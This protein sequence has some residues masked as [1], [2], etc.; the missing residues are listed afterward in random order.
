MDYLKL[1]QTHEE[2]EAFVS[3][4]TMVKPNVS[5]CV[6]EN[7][8]HYN[9]IEEKLI[10]SYF[11]YGG[12]YHNQIYCYINEGGLEAEIRAVDVFDKVEIDGVEVSTSYLDSIEAKYPF[13]E[14]THTVAYTLKDPTKIDDGMFSWCDGLTSVVFP[15]TIR[16]IGRESFSTCRDLNSITFRNG[17]ISIGTLAFFDCFSLTSITFPESITNIGEGCFETCE[18]IESVTVK[19]SVPPTLGA[20]VFEYS[21]SIITIYVPSE[22]VNTY[23]TASG[24]STY[25]N[26]IQAIPTT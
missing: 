10:I 19:A 11:Q 7:E 14:G 2:Y 23:K 18:H 20:G 26:S 13:S 21:S 1:F 5:H 4:G 9:P 22:S 17:L 25:A 16:T 24:W 6:Q 12:N 8:V 15:K 3:G